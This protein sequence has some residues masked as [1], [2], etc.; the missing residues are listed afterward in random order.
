MATKKM[1]AKKKAVSKKKSVTKKKATVKKKVATKKPTTKRK[2]KANTKTK[3]KA[4]KP[5]AKSKWPKGYN[6][7]EVER[8]LNIDGTT[9]LY[10]LVEVAGPKMDK[11][12]YFVDEESAKQYI[13]KME[14]ETLQYKALTGKTHGGLLARGIIKETMD[15]KAQAEL[16]EVSFEVPGDRNMARNTEDMDK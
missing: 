9:E 7:A 14:V 11:P 15:L 5:R 2:V 6:V 13:D 4:R 8:M 10:S 16:P 1:K 3:A 12:R